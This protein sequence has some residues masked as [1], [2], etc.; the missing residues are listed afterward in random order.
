MADTMLLKELCAIPGVSGAEELVRERIRKEIEPYADSIL[1]TPLGSLIAEKRGK[2]RAKTKLMLDAHMDEVGFIV[3][4]VGDAGLLK[5]ST[6]GGITGFVMCGRPVV[7]CT[8]KGN[9]PGVIG[10]K[11]IH[12]LKDGERDELVPVKDLYIDIGAENGEEARQYVLPG[13][14]VVFASPWDESRG[15]I[16]GRALDDRAGCAIL[17]GMMQQELEYDMTFVFSTQEETGLDGARTAS[18]TVQPQAAIVVESTT[19]ADV[20]GVPEDRQVCR[21]GQGP[22]LSFMDRHTVYDREMFRL[23]LET[24]REE[25]IPC[26]VKQAVAGGNNAGSISVSRGGV[27]TAAVSL[28]CRYLHSPIGLISR[29]DFDH[30]AALVK[31]LAEKVAGGAV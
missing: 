20:A 17:I 29:S 12:L 16:R 31:A 27:R 21:V 5:F 4:H 24:A 19:A 13:D 30:A 11:P 22:V 3:T 18:Y 2:A 25:G 26:Q 28:A 1:V 7:V 23:A 9:L 10:A 6:V 8:E 14:R 15:M